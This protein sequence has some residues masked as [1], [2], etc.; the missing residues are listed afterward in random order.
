MLS[1]ASIHRAV[2]QARGCV[3]GD[4]YLD[5]AGKSV[6]FVVGKRDSLDYGR[7]YK[8]FWRLAGEHSFEKVAG[9]IQRWAAS[10]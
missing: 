1:K 9:I 7:T 3:Q 2:L 10:M 5:A 4:L 8:D 6:S